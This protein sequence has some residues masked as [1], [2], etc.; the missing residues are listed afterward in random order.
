MPA[1]VRRSRNNDA[2]VAEWDDGRRVTWYDDG[3][4]KVGWPGSPSVVVTELRKFP[5]Q[6]DSHVVVQFEVPR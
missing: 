4:V 2:D 5:G 6:P 3:R 1:G